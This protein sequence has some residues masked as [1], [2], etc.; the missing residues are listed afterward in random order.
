VA[1]HDICFL[2]ATTLARLI[3]LG[4]L[5]A[6]EVLEAHLNQIERVNERVNAI[7][8]LAPERALALAYAADEAA[9]RGEPLGPLHGLPI[10]H[11][12]LVPTRGMRTTFGSTL[13]KNHVPTQDALIVQR[14]RRAGAIALGKTN[15][16]EFGA[17]SQTFN[18]VFG[19]TRNPYDVTKTCGGSSGGAAV[20]LA[21]GM[22][23]IADGSDVGG[24]LRNPAAFCNVVGLRPTPGRVPSWPTTL[25]GLPMLVE[26]P[27]ARTVS[28][29]AMLLTALEG[30]DQRVPYSLP[31]GHDGIPDTLERAFD[32]VRVAWSPTLGGLPVDRRVR[33]CVEA[34]QSTFEEL[35][36]RIDETDPDLTGADDWFKTWRA[37]RS[38][39]VFDAMGIEAEQL[40]DTLAAEVRRGRAITGRELWTA[41]VARTRLIERFAAFMDT[42]DF[43]VAPVTQVPPFDVRQPFVTAIEDVQLESYIDWMRSCYY[44]SVL[45]VPAISVPCGFTPEG[46][47]VGL[48]IIGRR[49]DDGG[50]LQLAYAFEQATMLWRRRPPLVQEPAV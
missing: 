18:E 39:A 24:S 17:G 41:E 47:P 9:A 27:M 3:R 21:C 23:P 10:A 46:L 12:D 15:T 49:H 32:Q 13:F 26:G 4:E 19:A 1:G 5:S 35:G 20:A 6:R 36:C 28:D 37:W 29:V 38:A 8:T 30:Q 48:Q 50:V 31:G 43:L 25:A 7:V 40:K 22:I 14:L 11:K 16:P 34:Q 33:A 44:V 2:T 45:E 42:Y